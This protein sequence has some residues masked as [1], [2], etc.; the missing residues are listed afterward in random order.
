MP[1]IDV[2]YRILHEGL[3]IDA[4]VRQLMGR[5]LKQEH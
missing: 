1:I 3:P 5:A 4:A 2:V